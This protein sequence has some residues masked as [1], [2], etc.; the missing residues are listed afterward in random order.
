[1]SDAFNSNFKNMLMYV[2]KAATD[3]KAKHKDCPMTSMILSELITWLFDD[4]ERATKILGKFR[5]NRMKIN[6]KYID[7]N[8]ESLL[9]PESATYTDALKRRDRSLFKH[10]D[11]FPGDIA[12]KYPTQIQ[13]F[14]EFLQQGVEERHMKFVWG[15]LDKIDKQAGQLNV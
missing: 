5:E 6:Q 7:G 1:M 15:Y 14:S 10:I 4:K 12:D 13:W 11:L 3:P 8:G 2:G 9:M